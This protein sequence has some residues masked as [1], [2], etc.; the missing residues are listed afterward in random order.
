MRVYK[1]KIFLIASLIL[2]GQLNFPA[3]AS[4]LQLVVAED[5][6]T[7]YNRSLFKHWIDADKD[8]CNTRAEVLIEEAVVKPKIG[9]KCKLTGGEWV[10]AYDGKKVTNASQLDVDHLVPLA[11]AWR[12]GAWKWT[13]A[14]RQAYANDLDNSEALIAVTLTTNRSKGDKDPYLWTPSKNYCEYLSSWLKIKSKYNLAVDTLEWNFFKV[15]SESK[16]CNFGELNFDANVYGLKSM[17]NPIATIGQLPTN[18][19][20]RL[21][22]NFTWV[23]IFVP[24]Y[25]VSNPDQYKLS[26]VFSST[27]DVNLRSDIIRV[28]H[29]NSKTGPDL[30]T[31]F[32]TIP[33]TP[34]TI[35]CA[36]N[37]NKAFYF[38]TI[39]RPLSSPKLFVSSPK[40]Y[41]EVG[42]VATASSTPTPSATPQNLVVSPGAFCSP[43]GAIG[44]SASGVTYTCKT[45]TTDTRNRWRQ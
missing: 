41:V 11:E 33:T 39:A 13:A 20:D 29:L 22:D 14:Q 21:N 1:A 4:T 42:I 35:Y 17:E 5:K 31:Y 24:K 37:A 18:P 44:K 10:S 6:T 40:I 30:L 43:A 36:T 12:S 38:N 27:D 16:T 8:G 25:D 28:C 34:I 19:S 32:G 7:G 15:T 23:E 3:S 26:A 45:S 9:P 2:A